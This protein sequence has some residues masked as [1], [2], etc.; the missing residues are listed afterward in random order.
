MKVGIR[1][2]NVH[3]DNNC[4]N[5][6]TNSHKTNFQMMPSQND[7]KY[8]NV[9]EFDFSYYVSPQETEQDLYPAPYDI[10]RQYCQQKS[11]EHP[12]YINCDGS[13]WNN[14]K[15]HSKKIDIDNDSAGLP[16]LVKSLCSRLHP[17]EREYKVVELC[18]YTTKDTRLAHQEAVT[19]LRQGNEVKP[20]ISNCGLKQIAVSNLCYSIQE[21]ELYEAN[22]NGKTNTKIK[23]LRLIFNFHYV[24]SHNCTAERNRQILQNKS[25]LILPEL[26]LKVGSINVCGDR[27]YTCNDQHC[28]S[29]E[30]VNDG[31]SDCPD[32]SD[33]VHNSLVCQTTPLP[34]NYQSEKN[35]RSPCMCP[36]DKY[37]CEGGQCINWN[38][39]CDGK[40]DC[41][42]AIDEF[43]C[44]LS[45][46]RTYD[47][48]FICNDGSSI[49][50]D[51][52]DDFLP[53]C[54]QAEDERHLV[55]NRWS[56]IGCHNAYHIPCV[57]G[58]PRCFPL[59]ALCVYDLDKHGNVRYCRNGAH[60]AQCTYI[61]CPY[62]F[63]CPGS[64]C[65]P[66]T[67]LCNNVNDC[68]FGEDEHMCDY[69]THLRCPGMFY[70]RGGSCVHQLQ[71]CDGENDCPSS[72]DENNCDRKIPP[73]ICQTERNRLWSTFSDDFKLIDLYKYRVLV[74]IGGAQTLD[75]LYNITD[76]VLLNISHNY[77]SQLKPYQFIDYIMLHI[78]D[79]S[80]NNIKTLAGNTFEGLHSLSRIVLLGNK[81]S[82]V[83]S[84]TFI[85]LTAVLHLDLSNM[86]LTEIQLGSFNVM[87]KLQSVDLSGNLLEILDANLHNDQILNNVNVT[88]NPL[89]YFT[90]LKA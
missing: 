84:M 85:G 25:Y 40:V 2:N 47:S 90:P 22:S 53:D 35:E 1:R 7:K 21:Q 32:G 11:S 41:K 68:P 64:Y 88:N 14:E 65:I 55:H 27:Q 78:L 5:S 49:P 52:V 56:S 3:L 44:P 30:Y 63:K 4:P 29:D 57:P 80:Y 31:V 20:A 39:I 50:Y 69:S 60:L 76:L 62:K 87:T 10:Y 54:E 70:C 48:T 18:S 19:V 28:I 83:S 13:I 26:Y 42:G 51:L 9:V 77:F 61:G 74:L 75:N 58:H 34:S 16:K 12:L 17:R 24:T 43:N 46:K 23:P 71:I 81:L 45:N 86:G 38:Q 8:V 82:K 37:T 66:I 72:D 73:S 67:S 36:C 6:I 89:Q 15:Y 59:Y 79:M 33:E